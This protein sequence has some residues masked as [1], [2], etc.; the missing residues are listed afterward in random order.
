MIVLI[1][2]AA[3]D[4]F[5]GGWRPWVVG[6]RPKVCL[7][8]T[9]ISGVVAQTFIDVIAGRRCGKVVGTS[10]KS[11]LTTIIKAVGPHPTFIN[12]FARAPDLLEPLIT[13]TMVPTLF[14]HA[15]GV[16]YTFMRSR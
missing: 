4:V 6:A 16:L 9:I 13:L 5:T 7:P 14:I 3:V 11:S 15:L 1:H 10:P 2:R 8:T 12:I